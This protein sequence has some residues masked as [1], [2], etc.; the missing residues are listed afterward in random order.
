M[1]AQ[2]ECGSFHTLALDLSKTRLYGCGQCDAGQLGHTD[3]DLGNDKSKWFVTKLQPVPFPENDIEI[4]EIAC[5]ENHNLVIVKPSTGRREVY[6]W[7]FGDPSGA[8]GHGTETIEF[9][10]KKVALPTK[11]GEEVDGVWR[12]VSGGAQ[13]SVFLF[14]PKE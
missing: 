1:L 14:S 9:R 2:V 12:G 7:G 5:G 8:L 10:P 4:E 6:T 11:G 3:T 13:H